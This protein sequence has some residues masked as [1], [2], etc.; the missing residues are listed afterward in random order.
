MLH[1]V[2]FDRTARGIMCEQ[3]AAQFDLDCCIVLLLVCMSLTQETT[4]SLGQ[5]IKG[6]SVGRRPSFVRLFT[7]RTSSK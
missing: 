5:S 6:S 3:T 4:A 7:G 2:L 1:A